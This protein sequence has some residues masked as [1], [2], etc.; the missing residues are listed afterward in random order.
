MVRNIRKNIIFVFLSLLLISGIKLA[1]DEVTYAYNENDTSKKNPLSYWS[2]ENAPLFYGATNITLQ[3]G[4]I[5]EFDVLDTRFRIF[6]KD[7][8]DGDLTPNITSEGTVN[9]NEVGTYTISYKVSDS[10]H[11]E[12]TI[13][14]PVTVTEDP[15]VQIK[16]ERTL[17]TLPSMWNL[18]MVGVGRCNSGDRQ[19]LGVY[20]SQGQS[21]KARIIEADNN[22]GVAFL[23]NDSA[24]E[25]SASISKNGEWITLQNTK[26]GTGYNSVPLITSTVLSRENTDLTKTFKIELEYGST[27]PSLN[28]YHYKDS[29]QSFRDKW[30][31]TQNNFAVI[32]NEV[33]TIVVPYS[34]INKTTNY[35]SKGFTSLDQF[36]EYYKKVVDK[37]DEYIGLDLNPIELT[38]QNVRI[39]YLVKANAHG[40][41][42]AYYAGNH[43]GINNASVASFFEMNWG[44]LHE[45]AHGYQGNLGKGE[46]GLGET[47]NN[48]LGHY[49]QIDKNIY[50]HSGDWLG[51]MTSIE[52]NKNNIRLNAEEYN[53]IDVS[54]RL[55]YIINLFDTFEGGTTYAKMFQWFRKEVNNK[56]IANMNAN[57]D[58]YVRAIADIYH[59]NIIPYMEAWKLTISPSIKEEVYSK[60]Y[61]TLNI[62]KDTVTEQSLD[63]IMTGESL[64]RKYGLVSNDVLKKYNITGNLT[65]TINI[66]DISK[67]NGKYATLKQGNSVIKQVKITSNQVNITNLPV[68]SYSLQMPVLSDYNQDYGYVQIKE[69]PNNSYTYEYHAIEKKDYSNYVSLK[70]QG[71]YGT[72]GYELTFSENYTKGKVHLN[73]ANMGDSAETYVKIYDETGALIVEEH[74]KNYDGIMYFEDNNKADYELTFNPGYVIE[75]KHRNYSNRIKVISTLTGKEISAYKPTEE[76]T[77]YIVTANGLR[78]E[79]MTDEEVQDIAYN[80]LKEHLIQIIETYKNKVTDDELNNK[81]INFK[82]KSEV[83]SAYNQLKKE[84]QIPYTELITRIRRGGTPTIRVVGKLEYVAGETLDLYSIINATDNEDGEIVI[85]KNSTTIYSTIEENKNGIYSVF[86]E[87]KDSDGNVATCMLQ[88]IVRGYDE[89]I[90]L[91]TE[92]TQQTSSTTT[93]NPTNAANNSYLTSKNEQVESSASEMININTSSDTN[94]EEQNNQSTGTQNNT[95]N[96][97]KPAKDKSPISIIEDKDIDTKIELTKAVGLG[98]MIFI[99]LLLAVIKMKKVN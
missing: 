90:T 8:E 33:L 19:I 44:G 62:L 85:N 6:A 80:Q 86:Y 30:N 58:L 60:G 11:N 49:I 91:P 1:Y 13:T 18:D 64:S 72:Y 74:T 78:K 41:G 48:I 54:T 3:K 65:L 45:I 29:E 57:Q 34:D 16:V 27:I 97:T 70:L 98:F 42:A 14:V 4:I 95:S 38:D 56:N 46:M 89:E 99:G 21:I 77:K 83:L 67:L 9:V 24:L 37:M 15:D 39:K 28:Y 5:D 17:Y 12:T 40:A 82:E 73:G 50:F 43:V 26:D 55:Y 81:T 88:I 93:N 92:T 87:V 71:I 69:S 2:T 76:V 7:F 23:A 96:K 25:S 51:N 59:V 35:F 84:D 61:P 75:V 20:L 10:H 52:E 32:E 63:K 66:D 31:T 22:I 94:K 53:S 36:L 68:G 47:A 79:S